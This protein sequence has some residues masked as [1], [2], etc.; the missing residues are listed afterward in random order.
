M[1]ENK[2][3]FENLRVYQK[4]LDYVNFIYEI[5]RS[6]PKFETYSLID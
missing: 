5:T 6:F 4:T 1:N 2:F 3:D